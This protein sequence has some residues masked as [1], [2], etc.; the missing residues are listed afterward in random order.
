MPYNQNVQSIGLADEPNMGLPAPASDNH[1]SSETADDVIDSLCSESTWPQHIRIN[2][3]DRVVDSAVFHDSL[4][5]RAGLIVVGVIA[6]LGLAWIVR[7][8][9]S[10]SHLPSSP[11]VQIASSA[12]IP[13]SKGDPIEPL[14][15]GVREAFVEAS[16][17]AGSEHLS[18]STSN[19]PKLSQGAAAPAGS[20]MIGHSSGLQRN[21]SSIRVNGKETDSGTRRTPVPETRPTTI[22]GWTVR[23]VT[24]GIAALEG[25]N[26]ILKVKRG[27][28]V[29]GLGRIDSIVLWGQR[30]IVATRRG[31]ISTP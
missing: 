6:L 2:Q 9:L 29:P 13:D 31:L 19:R 14:G 25:P 24:N 27:D 11:T 12:N 22:E 5:I 15:S 26:G 10:P 4:L 7:S 16:A 20:S 8:S 18:S 21:T 30:W 23:E 28:V 1:E 17:E 3:K